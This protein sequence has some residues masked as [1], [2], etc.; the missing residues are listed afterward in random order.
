MLLLGYIPAQAQQTTFS[1]VH[2]I[3]QANCTI[4]CHS[5]SSPAANLNLSGTEQE[6]YD[7]IV[8]VDPVNPY[9]NDSLKSKLV[10][11]G[12]PNKSFL[13]RKVSNGLDPWINMENFAEG[14]PMPDGQNPLEN[15][16]IELIRQWIL[17]GARDTGNYVNPTTLQNFYGGLGLPQIDKPRS[18]EEDGLEGYQ[19]RMGPIFLDPLEEIEYFYKQKI[20]LPGEKEGIRISGTLNDESH[21]FALFDFEHTAA[22]GFPEGMF[23][24]EGLLLVAYIH[25][26]STLLGAWQ[27]NRDM[28]LPENTAFFWDENSTLAINYHILNYDA[29]SILAAD[30]WINIYTEDVEENTRE[31]IS[32]V[33]QK[34]HDNPYLLK[35]PPTAPGETYTDGFV[36]TQPGEVWDLWSFQA[37]THAL[38]RD[39][40]VYLMNPDSTIGEQIYEGFYD[41]SYSFDQ[42]YFDYAHPP[43]KTWEDPFLT[44]NMDYG[45]YV[46]AK[47][48][49]PGQDT[50]TFGFTTEDEMFAFYLHYLEHV[51]D[52]V[53][54]IFEY[55]SLANVT[56]YPN[57]VETISTVNVSKEIALTDAEFVMHDMM[58]KEVRRIAGINKNTILV[59]REDLPSGI[60][61][62]NITQDG[63]LVGT[64]KLMMK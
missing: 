62:Y 5:G 19:V 41:P 55:G 29:D 48:E 22:S 4:G 23:E 24:V 11:P 21:H 57:P 52:T 33:D 51:P 17:F 6:V 61:V 50:V 16:E 59:T 38:G 56:A 35:I 47:F 12:Y 37:H 8:D 3:L 63:K 15:W 1:Q 27:Y 13:L 64:G 36:Y 32:V 31:I 30:A 46:E 9:A 20:D 28:Q 25:Q 53:D 39:Y 54:G 49:N 26:N 58:G 40:D 7:A 14:N 45:F 10:A 34:G 60:Y 2:S 43:T 42:G 44:V 18:P